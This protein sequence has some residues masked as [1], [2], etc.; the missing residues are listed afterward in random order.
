MREDAPPFK[1][2]AVGTLVS[3][4]VVCSTQLVMHRQPVCGVYT[5]HHCAKRRHV[6]SESPSYFRINPGRTEELQGLTRMLE[7]NGGVSGT[8]V[9]LLIKTLLQGIDNNY[10]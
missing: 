5:L 2:Q 7:Q 9:P 8:V 6:R 4:A 1:Q 3:M 10:K